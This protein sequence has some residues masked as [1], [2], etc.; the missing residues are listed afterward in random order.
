MII[1]RRASIHKYKYLP[2][3]FANAYARA[4]FRTL[5]DIIDHIKEY[6]CTRNGT[7]PDLCIRN[8]GT[9][10]A[11]LLG[12][13]LDQVGFDWTAYILTPHHYL[14]G[15]FKPDL[16]DYERKFIAV[17]LQGVCMRQGP[18]VFSIAITI[19]EKLDIEAYF[20]GSLESWIN[21]AID[22]VQNKLFPEQRQP[23]SQP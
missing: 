20:K 10:C 22:S 11:A 16:T 4:N 21:H 3:R 18:E 19:T 6:G 14:T 15:K 2:T 12:E 13:L 23:P 5:Q 7:G 1:E 8:T 17:A 9:L